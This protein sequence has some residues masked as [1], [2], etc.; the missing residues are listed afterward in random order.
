MLRP[1]RSSDGLVD[2]FRVIELP[3]PRSSSRACSTAQHPGGP[4]A[5]ALR[6][7]HAIDD[8]EHARRPPRRPSSRGHQ[9]E[10]RAEAPHAQ[11]PRRGLAHLG[12]TEPEPSQ[13]GAE[14]RLYPVDHG[15]WGG[16]A[17]SVA[18]IALILRGSRPARRR[19]WRSARSFT[20]AVDS[21]PARSAARAG[22]PAMAASAERY[23]DSPT[24]GSPPTSTS[25]A[26]IEH[27]VRSSRTPVEM[28]RPPRPSRS[29]SR[30]RRRGLLGRRG[31]LRGVSRTSRSQLNAGFR[32]HTRRTRATA[33]ARRPTASGAEDLCHG[34]SLETRPPPRVV[35]TT[36]R[37][38]A[39]GSRKT[40]TAIASGD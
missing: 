11:E 8:V 30:R 13:V 20:C 5:V 39:G 16:S 14:E 26:G 34:R 10:R 22:P 32:T 19:R 24:P 29:T 28:R 18:Q 21:S 4:I 31:G 6:D 38:C 25:E 33:V 23:V 12:A 2:W 35:S 17:S 37:S 3:E 36:I 1:K 27:A 7:Q 15:I 9:E 40:A